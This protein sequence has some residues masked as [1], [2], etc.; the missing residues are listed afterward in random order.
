M[1]TVGTT[2]RPAYI[3]DAETDTWVPVGV[4][5]HSHANFVESTVIDAKGDLI[6]GSAPDTVAKFPIGANGTMLVA[7]ATETLGMAWRNNVTVNSSTDA[8]RITQTG[9]G[10]AFVVEDSANPDSSPFVIDAAGNL[11]IGSDSPPLGLSGFSGI[12]TFG[13][14]LYSQAT[15]GSQPYMQM[16]RANGTT[17]S[18]TIV[19]NNDAIGNLAFQGWDGTARRTGA[20][21][22]GV[23]DGT[24]GVADMPTR[25]VFSTT[26]DGAGGPNERMRIDNAG[27]V[28]IGTTT[29]TARLDVNGDIRHNNQIYAGKNK[30]I[31]GGF[32]VWQRGTSGFSNGGFT[33]DRMLSDNGATASR[34]TDAPNGF[35]YSMRWTTPGA[36]NCVIRQGIELPAAGSQGIFFDGSAFTF[37]IFAKSSVAGKTLTL[38]IAFADGS[39]GTA[40]RTV[41]DNIV[42][43]TT[44]TGWAR[45]THTF[46]IPAGASISPALCLQVTPYIS[47]PNADVYMTG[48]QLEAGSVATPFTLAGGG[49]QQ[50]ELALCQ[51]YYET[52]V[53]RQ[54]IR[55]PSI[56]DNHPFGAISGTHFQV[57]K[58]ATP[59]ITLGS[60]TVTSCY[61]NSGSTENIT[62][63]GFTQ[64]L[65]IAAGGAQTNMSITQPWTASIEL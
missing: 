59:T 55:N 64:I 28:G 29:P 12:S 42:I 4:G 60:N 33:A 19:A 25:L 65:L 54:T 11:V 8:F 61:T 48:M 34:S 30:I 45:Y 35:M 26:P 32:D 36:A 3:Y 56:A 16:V 18:P 10:N 23:I 17:A 13:S 52:G 57:A 31:N 63:S 53:G 20:L 9:S 38:Y 5:P 24:P 6:V 1:A 47:T 37:S 41:V 49:S 46:T 27:N 15:F 44:T 7:D 22:S 62:T 39:N 2:P 14:A 40:R 43:G 51:R 50:A 21:I 58:R